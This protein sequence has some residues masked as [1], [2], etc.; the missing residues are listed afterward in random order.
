MNH[1]QNLGGIQGKN[2]DTTSYF[3]SLDVL[4]TNHLDLLKRHRESGNTPEFLEE[5]KKFIQR[6]RA[7]GALLDDEDDRWGAQ[8]LLDYWIS[9]LAHAGFESPDATLV[10]FDP[11][12]EAV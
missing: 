11:D 9:L 2:D 10:D 12:L 1:A 8:S 7:T 4:R 5:I 6:G 3:P